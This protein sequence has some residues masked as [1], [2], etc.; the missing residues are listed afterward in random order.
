MYASSMASSPQRAGHGDGRPGLRVLLV[1]KGPPARDGIATFLR[2]VQDGLGGIHRIE[3]LNLTREGDAAG[4]RLSLANIRRAA[5]DTRAVWRRS[6]GADVVHIHSALAPHVTLVRAGMLAAAARTRGCGVLLHA[7][8]GLV[9]LWLTTRPRRALARVAL[10]A[11]DHV[12]AVSEGGREALAAALGKRRV[13]L[14]D[15]W[16]DTGA[17]SPPDAP[18]EPP[19]ILYAGFIT[20]R[21][22]LLDL[23]AASRLLEERGVAHELLLAGGTPAEGPHAEEEVRRAAGPA[24]RLLGSRPLEAMPELYGT[25]D[26][27]CLPSWWEAMPLSVLEAM[28]AGLPVVATRVGDIPRAVEDGVTGLLVPPRDPAALASALE[29]LLRG[30]EDRRAMGAAGRARVEGRFGA[31]PGLAAIDR[32]YLTLDRRRTRGRRPQQQ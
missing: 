15:N 28:A 6:R 4:G 20:P 9:K 22:G 14:I 8:G 10:A 3:L 29:Q 32:L 18:H 26:V 17:F 16:I 2:S 1:G 13:D 31:G 21:K 25:A 5:A 7:H 12:V 11:A 19:R 27:F 23:I 30:P 24:V